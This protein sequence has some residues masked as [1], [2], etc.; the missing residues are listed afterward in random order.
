MLTQDKERAERGL[1]PTEMEELMSLAR[2]AESAILKRKGKHRVAGVP[3]RLR[4]GAAQQVQQDSDRDAVQTRLKYPSDI[5]MR[6]CLRVPENSDRR[7]CHA[8][9]KARHVVS[10]F[11]T[12]THANRVIQHA[13]EKGLKGSDGGQ[14][15]GNNGA[16]NGSL[17][18]DLTH[19]K[20]PEVRCDHCGT[21]GH[22]KAQCWIAN[23][24]LKLPSLKPKMES[25]R[26]KQMASLR[27]TFAQDQHTRRETGPQGERITFPQGMNTGAAADAFKAWFSVAG[28]HR[29]WRQQCATQFSHQRS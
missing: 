9:K 8:Y 11:P 10:N 22:T 26:Q 20:T 12:K 2:K 14:R 16:R 15:G 13:G 24:N 18:E 17:R 28:C 29:Q 7:I 19:H 4:K 21:M 25:K 6:L 3:L 1:P 5:S 23:P 27:V